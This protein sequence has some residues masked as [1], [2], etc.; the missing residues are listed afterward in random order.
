M[1]FLCSVNS[2]LLRMSFVSQKIMFW[3]IK[4]CVLCLIW[5]WSWNKT[6]VLNFVSKWIRRQIFCVMHIIQKKKKIHFFFLLI[7]TL[8]WVSSLRQPFTSIISPPCL[9]L[10]FCFCCTRK[11]IKRTLRVVCFLLKC[12][13]HISTVQE[14]LKAETA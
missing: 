1:I 14:S 13:Y 9:R 3:Q 6:K 2:L 7:I 10:L 12:S 5:K 4:L 8:R 11:C